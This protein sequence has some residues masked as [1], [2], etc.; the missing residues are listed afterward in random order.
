M[1]NMYTRMVRSIIEYGAFI[2]QGTGHIGQLEAVQRKALAIC[3]NLPQTSDREAME[4]AAMILPLDLR[5][6]E[7]VFRKLS[8]IQAKKMSHPQKATLNDMM[9]TEPIHAPRHVSPMALAICQ[10]TEMENTTKVSFRMIEPEKDYEDGSLY[11]S[12]RHPEYWSRLGSSKILNQRTRNTGK[13]SY[14]GS[15]DGSTNGHLLSQMAHA[16][17]TLVPVVPE[18]SFSHLLE[19]QCCLNRQFPNSGPFY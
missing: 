15:H 16:S 19:S 17:L 13:R 2:W 4:V 7:T 3:L 8:K 5:L 14:N 18:Q 9:Q 1:I 6:S 12:L 10:A 11:R